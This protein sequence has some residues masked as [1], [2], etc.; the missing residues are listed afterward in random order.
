MQPKKTPFP[1]TIKRGGKKKPPHV[2]RE[3]QKKNPNQKKKKNP[4]T[5]IFQ[6]KTH[7]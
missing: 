3:F 2:R 6:Q 5:K 7:V 4:Q 1:D